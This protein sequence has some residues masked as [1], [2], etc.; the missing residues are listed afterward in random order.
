MHFFEVIHTADEKFI[1]EL[2]AMQDKAYPEG[3]QY[4]DAEDY[5][6]KMIQDPE[7]LNII[8]KEKE[9]LIGYILAIPH[10]NAMTELK[11][12]DP[13]MAEDSERF[14]IE[15]ME[16]L[17]EIQK[18]LGGGKLFFRMLGKL[19][20]EAEKRGIHKFSMHARVSTGLSNSVQRYFGK[21]MTEV[22]RIEKWPFYNGD[23]STDY[24][25]GTYEKK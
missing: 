7:N 16:M 23:E 4:A 17:P 6:R 13:L 14:Y 18:T 22:R 8:L 20:A 15:T 24:M 9:K 11:E 3:W 21:M 10:N 19:F 1:K 25:L 5:Y 2:L 12:V